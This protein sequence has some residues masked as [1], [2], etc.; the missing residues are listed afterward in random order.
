MV[1]FACSFCKVWVGLGRGVACNA[2]FNGCLSVLVFSVGVVVACSFFSVWVGWG[3]CFAG[4]ARLS[5]VFPFGFARFG[6]LSLVRF[7]LFG[8]VGARVCS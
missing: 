8:S 2:A 5:I 3:A 4:N 6:L 7:A 1:A